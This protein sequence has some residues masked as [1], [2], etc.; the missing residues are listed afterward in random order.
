MKYKHKNILGFAA[1][2]VGL[3]FS[4]TGCAE[5]QYYETNHHHTRG[6]YEHHHEPP[7]PNV[8]FELEIRQ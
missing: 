4:L 3:A 8:N 5:H 6:W 1:L 2:L 7:P